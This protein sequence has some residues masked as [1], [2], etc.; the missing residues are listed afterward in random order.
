L[1]KRRIKY[2][3][4]AALVVLSAIQ[5]VPYGRTASNPP[6]I[7]EPEW[8]TKATRDLVVRA[9]FDCHSNETHYPWYSRVAPVSWW[10][11]NHIDEGRD[12]LNFS[13]WS[14][15]YD[16]IDEIAES[17]MEGEMPPNYYTLI[18][19]S[20]NLSERERENLIRGL[21]STFNYSDKAQPS[22][23]DHDDD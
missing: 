22:M 1:V 21:I 12:D 6:I 7:N 20:R 2:G 4:V 5:I 18:P 3:I 19:S 10:T 17:V 11:Q 16:E 9:C 23:K 8:D 15:D 13:E 14:W